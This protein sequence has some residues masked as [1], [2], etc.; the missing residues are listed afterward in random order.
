[1]TTPWTSP[2]TSKWPC[3]QAIYSTSQ[4]IYWTDIVPTGSMTLQGVRVGKR[5]K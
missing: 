4:M 3:I 5:P 1:M 2:E